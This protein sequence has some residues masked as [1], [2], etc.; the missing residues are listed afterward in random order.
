MTFTGK[1]GLV[2]YTSF[3]DRDGVVTFA[4]AAKDAVPAGTTLATLTFTAEADTEATFTITTVEEGRNKPGTSETP[5][6]HRAGARLYR[7]C[8]SRDLHGR[9]LYP[10]YLPELRLQL[11]G[12]LHR[13]S[14]P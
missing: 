4:Y 6:G 12:S 2:D 10:V 7:L 14:G 8:G 13:G 11:Q 5:D 1:S 9:R 3:S